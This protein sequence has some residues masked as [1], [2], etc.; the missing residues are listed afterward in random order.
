MWKGV[1]GLDD[2]VWKVGSIILQFVIYMYILQLINDL[3]KFKNFDIRIEIG[4]ILSYNG[5][6]NGR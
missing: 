6:L 2:F 5:F 1:E 3:V 4:S